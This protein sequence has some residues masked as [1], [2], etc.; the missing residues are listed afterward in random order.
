MTQKTGKYQKKHGGIE[1][2]KGLEREVMNKVL[3]AVDAIMRKFMGVRIEEL[4]SDITSKLKDPLLGFEPTEFLHLPLKTAR[5]LFRERYLRLL[6]KQKYG[7][8]SE[9]AKIAEIERRSVHRLVSEAGIDVG[10]IRE[11]MLKPSYVKELMIERTMHE[12]IKAYEEVLHPEKIREIYANLSRISKD[13]VKEI[14]DNPRPLKEV[15]REFEKQYFEALQFTC[16]TVA[17]ISKKAGMRYETVHRK[18]KKL[19]LI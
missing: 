9:V 3:P 13:I 5:Q 16:K 18:M 1:Q 17:K 14:P 15:E 4:G 10:K 7:N 2:E 12:V 6:L 19:G 11:E 8:I